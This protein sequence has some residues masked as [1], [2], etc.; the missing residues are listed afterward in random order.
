MLKLNHC[1]AV[2]KRT[3][4]SHIEDSDTTTDVSRHRNRWCQAGLACEATDGIW[5]LALVAKGVL[6]NADLSKQDHQHSCNE[7]NSA[8]AQVHVGK[9]KQRR[10]LLEEPVQRA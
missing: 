7:G 4:P 10:L 2:Q 6:L 9:S 1:S 5:P 3:P 8:Q